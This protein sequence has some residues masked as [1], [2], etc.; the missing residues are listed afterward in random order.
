MKKEIIVNYDY[1]E[2]LQ[3]LCEMDQKLIHLARQSVKDSYCPYS[4]FAVAACALLENG[5]IVCKCNYENASYS[6]TVCAERSIIAS[7]HNID[8]KIVSMAIS[9]K[10][11]SGL[12]D[13]PISPCGV[14]RQAL[15][16]YENNSHK[17]KIKYILSGQTGGILVVNGIDNLLPL[18]FNL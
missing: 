14:C 2:H 5:N 8:S 11:L 6:V 1:Y 7:V 13:I 9:Y 16:E 18:A 12:N 15:F 17:C 3:E 4:N 10:G